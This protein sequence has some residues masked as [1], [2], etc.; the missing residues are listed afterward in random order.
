M[1]DCVQHLNSKIHRG[2]S[3]PCPFC[4]TKFTSAS[5]LLH[6][7]ERGSCPAAPSLNHEKILA[8]VRERDP[9][10]TITNKQIEWLEEQTLEYRAT[11]QAYNGQAWECYLCHGTFRA[12]VG[13]N[14]HL[15]SPT[16]KEKVYHCP[17]FK[18]EKQF[19]TLASP[20]HHLESESCAFMR[21]ANVQ[22]QVQ[23]IVTGRKFI[24]F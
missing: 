6:H 22:K 9:H 3:L 12:M 19:I 1:T 21:F 7:L 13:L 16:H 4:K 24:S 8:I 5:G 15:N 20:F 11:N 17:N 18:C 14:R 2:T 10:G 23:G